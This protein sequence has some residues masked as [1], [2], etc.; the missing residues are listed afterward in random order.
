M[1]VCGQSKARCAE[2]GV[3]GGSKGEERG[4]RD[5]EL[6]VNGGGVTFQGFSEL[7]PFDRLTVRLDARR[8][9]DR[10]AGT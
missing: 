7:G 3:V 6:D 4:A 9:F 5:R 1:R 2:D 8:P 10:W